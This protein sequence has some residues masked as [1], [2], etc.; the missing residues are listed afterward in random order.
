MWGADCGDAGLPVRK[1]VEWRFFDRPAS[2]DGQRLACWRRIGA[3]FQAWTGGGGKCGGGG[4]WGGGG[5]G[6]GFVGVE[7]DG[8]E[9]TTL[10]EE[11]AWGVLAHP[12]KRQYT[13]P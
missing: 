10:F 7:K 13:R 5:G 3:R 9:G 6:E 4:F 12:H 8:G 2:G 1:Y 11:S